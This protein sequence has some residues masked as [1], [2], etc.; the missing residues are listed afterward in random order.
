VLD[1]L[2]SISI[3]SNTAFWIAMPSSLV[4]TFHLQARIL[5]TKRLVDFYQATRR[6]LPE[7]SSLPVIIM[8]VKTPT[9]DVFMAYDIFF[10]TQ[11]A[12]QCC[13][14]F[15][16]SREFHLMTSLGEGTDCTRNQNKTK[17]YVT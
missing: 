5:S 10:L 3:K 11:H 15:F 17:S 8:A 7:H 14:N 12:L 9:L 1:G 16:F 6:Q 13:F 2:F 4:E